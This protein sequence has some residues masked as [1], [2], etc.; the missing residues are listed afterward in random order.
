ME[1]ILSALKTAGRNCAGCMACEAV[2]SGKAIQMRADISGFLY[3]EVN[4]ESCNRC[5]ACIDVCP[6]LN[7]EPD[8][9]GKPLCFAAKADDEIRK[10]SSSGGI[11]PLLCDVVLSLGGVVYGAAADDIFT[12]R[13]R[14]ATDKEGASFLYRSKYVQSSMEGIYKDLRKEVRQGRTVLFSGTPCQVAAVRNFLGKDVPENVFLVDV[15]CHGVPSQKM[16]KDYLQ[17]NFCTEDIQEICFRN[18][19]PGWRS[20]EL[21]VTYR[22]G[23]KEV[24]GRTESF[25]EEG[26]LSD[27]SLREGCTNCV[28]ASV[29]RSG[30]LTIGDFWGIEKY[31]P[32]FQDHRGISEILVNNEKGQKLLDQIREKLTDLQEMPLEAA[33]EN[34]LQP[35]SPNPMRWRFRGLYRNKGFSESARAVMK[36]TYDVGLVAHYCANN[37]GAQLTQWALY[38]VLTEEG[39]SVLMIERPRDASPELKDPLPDLFSRDPYPDYAKSGLYASVEDMKALNERCR[40]FITG[41]DQMFNPYTYLHMNRFQGLNFVTDDHVKVGYALSWGR[42]DFPDDKAVL[43]EEAYYLEKYDAVSSR[44]DTGVRIL[45]EDF[46]ISEAAFVLDPLFLCSAQDMDQLLADYRNR[47]DLSGC[48][49]CVYVLDVSEEQV[50]MVIH[51]AKKC[52]IS[53]ILMFTDP[54]R[55]ERILQMVMPEDIQ[56]ECPED[57]TVEC[58][59]SVFR[60][61]EYVVTDSYHGTCLAILFRRQF[62]SMANKD[63]GIDRFTSLLHLL[64]LDD[65]LAYTWS[66]AEGKLEELVKEPISFEKAYRILE[67]ER[68]RSREWLLDAV[69]KTKPKRYSAYDVLDR[70]IEKAMNTTERNMKQLETR[71]Q[72]EMR[73]IQTETVAALE[74]EI[75]IQRQ[76]LEQK[77]FENSLLIHQLLRVTRWRRKMITAVRIIR[78]KGV[79]AAVVYSVEK[80]RNLIRNRLG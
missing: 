25:Y 32:E 49:I 26:F 14:K 41:S 7:W 48:Y 3:P 1:T 61:A 43:A 75:R 18:K 9:K 65:R 64:E 39:F 12:V 15:L 79:V 66:E 47:E 77:T 22:D 40:V 68:Q 17:E 55:R 50:R 57:Q 11:F 54:E 74:E 53:R 72:Q 59:I 58:L 4:Q 67:R 35:L 71:M 63:R 51:E 36:N 5:F 30:D 2:C 24:I 28:F 42:K 52:G 29:Q 13:H 60:G 27:F 44:E 20:D 45:R 8:E 34:R 19:E 33:M 10:A 56:I 46:G 70:K 21:L 31:A 73:A 69:R 37:F 6:V 16:W 38:H 62:V 23:K 78:Q 80:A 76:E